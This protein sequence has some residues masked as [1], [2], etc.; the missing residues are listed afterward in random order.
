MNLKRI[1][2]F[3]AVIASAGAMASSASA[4]APLPVAVNGNTVEAYATGVAVPTQM[5]FGAGNTFIAGAE[6]GPMKGGL[7]VVKPGESAATKVPGSPDSVFGVLWKKGTL[8]ATQGTDLVAY[9]KWNGTKFKK[10]QKLLKGP[11]TGFSGLAMGPN[12]R[13]Y[14]GVQLKQAFDHKYNP[15]KYANTVLSV[16]TSGKGLRVESKGLRQPWML[17]FAKGEKSPIVS[18]LAQDLPV[19]TKAPDLLVKA[20]PRSNFGFPK[21]NWAIA[22][23][24]KG[25]TKPLL[26]IQQGEGAASPMGL[27][28]DG[29]KIYLALFGGIGQGPGIATTNSSGAP[30]RPFVFRQGPPVLSVALHNGYVYYGDF[31][32]IYRVKM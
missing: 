12:G 4:L 16:K 5:T 27:A 22:A 7:Y 31:S 1:I 15:M 3:V 19:G 26:K 20:K 23:A 29:K 14:T 11:K 25:F 30:L 9:S 28:A 17:A 13:L 6:E 18:S 2:A 8:Y 10:K 32:G 21:C 24:C